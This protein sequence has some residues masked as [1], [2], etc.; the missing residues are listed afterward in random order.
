M[1]DRILN[2]KRFKILT[3]SE[4]LIIILTPERII[5]YANS[6]YHRFFVQNVDDV[7]GTYV[8][9]DFSGDRK[10]FYEHFT[11]QMSFEN[12]TIFTILKL[13]SESRERWV[14][15]TENGIYN[16]NGELIEILV[17]ARDLED[18]TNLKRQTSEIMNLLFAFR[19]AIDNNV[20]C[21]I[22]DEKG[23]ITY[24][25]NQ[26]CKIS[27]YS[28]S[29]L[30]GKTHSIIN[31]G[32]HPDTFFAKMWN[33]INAGE[34]WTGEVCNKAKNGSL[35]WVKTV[36]VPVLDAEKK[37]SQFLSLRILITKE[38]N[39]EQEKNDYLLSLEQLIFM[40]SHE[41]RTPIVNC[42][43]LISVLKNYLPNDKEFQQM[44]SYLQQ[45]V[46]KLDGYSRDM[47]KY[48]QDHKITTS[49]TSPDVS[50]ES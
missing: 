42:D 10:N 5:K 32:H 1:P 22:T 18:D 25:N 6:A 41:L 33:T 23:K 29:E 39:L 12:P 36:I 19:N 17:V 50:G 21:S 38:K 43:G 28:S 30:I 2:E 11:W 9:K 37:I 20:I 45:S 35:Y 46:V 4:E 44:I 15:W 47:N 16:D 14:R 24:V 40:V 27:Q 13:G 3:Q 8:A 26:F 48:L 31:S 34:A 7:V 49:G